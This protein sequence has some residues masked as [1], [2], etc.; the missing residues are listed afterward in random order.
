VLVIGEP[1]TLTVANGIE[2]VGRGVHRPC[3]LQREDEVAG[4]HFGGGVGLNSI[5]DIA[6]LE[7]VPCPG[8]APCLADA[9]GVHLEAPVVLAPVF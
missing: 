1:H 5:G 2:A 8:G 6:V 9:G 7:H 4:A 3:A